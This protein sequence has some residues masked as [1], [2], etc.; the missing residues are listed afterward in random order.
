MIF[1]F[2]FHIRRLPGSTSEVV[3]RVR[4]DVGLA[5]MRVQVI[6]ED[7]GELV[8]REITRACDAGARVVLL[9]LPMADPALPAAVLALEQIGCHF[10]G[11][12]FPCM[13]AG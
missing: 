11:S 2:D 8:R 6:G 9:D 12:A 7:L 1:K 3:I 13:N 10:A 4:P 5:T